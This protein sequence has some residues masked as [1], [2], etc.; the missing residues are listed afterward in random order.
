MIIKAYTTYRE[1]EIIKRQIELVTDR[2]EQTNAFY[3]SAGYRK[4]SE[5]GCCGFIKC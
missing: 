4:L 3:R 2:S 1:N 5:I